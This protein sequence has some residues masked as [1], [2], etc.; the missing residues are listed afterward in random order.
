[1]DPEQKPSLAKP[2]QRSCRCC[3]LGVLCSVFSGP[4][5]WAAAFRR[6]TLSGWLTTDHPPPVDYS[7]FNFSSPVSCPS[8]LPPLFNQHVLEEE[9]TV[10]VDVDQIGGNSEPKSTMTTTT[11]VEEEKSIL[12]RS[13]SS[14]FSFFLPSL[15]FATKC[16]F[17]PASFVPLLRALPR[18][19]S[20]AFS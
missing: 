6:A 9:E 14:S 2:N 17:A 4:L 19:V 5:S 15:G 8:S 7:S 11:R 18:S 13:F 12:K 1:M 10:P 3:S 16:K 20:P